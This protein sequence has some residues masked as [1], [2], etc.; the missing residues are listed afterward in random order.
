MGENNDMNDN[1]Y[2]EMCN[3]LKEKF[4]K[5][6]EQEREIK[7]QMVVVKQE[8]CK[9]Y[10]LTEAIDEYLLNNLEIPDDLNTVLELLMS[11]VKDAVDEHVFGVKERSPR[12]T[13]NFSSHSFSAGQENALPGSLIGLVPPP[14]PDQQ[15]QI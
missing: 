1:E 13:I 12:I 4:D 6:E 8:L 3:Q 11:T 15:T 14:S 5:V 9:I 10:G 7:K 2:L